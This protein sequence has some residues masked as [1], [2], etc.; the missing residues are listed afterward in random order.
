MLS[1]EGRRALATISIATALAAFGFAGC[2]DDETD[3]SG[4]GGAG[5]G[6]AGGGSGG[7]SG[8]AGSAG[9]AASDAPELPEVCVEAPS[10]AAW[11]GDASCPVAKPAASDALDEAFT[12]AGLDRCSYGFSAQTMSIWKT[13][14]A[15]DAYKLPIFV[16]LHEGLLRLPG[17]GRETE[18][19]LA[20]ALDGETPVADAI[21]AAAARK[22]P[23]IQGCADLTP[24]QAALSD[25]E[26]LARA[27]VALTEAHG[28]SADQAA[29]AAQTSG[30]PDELERALVPVLASL[31]F[32]VKEQQAAWGSSDPATLDWLAQI[33]GLLLASSSASFVFDQAHVAHLDAVDGA[34][35]AKAAAL[36]ARAVELADLGRF[37]GAALTNVSVDTPLGAIVIGAATGDTYSEGHA[38]ERS[39]LLIDVGGDDV[40]EVPVAAGRRDLPVSVAIDLGGADTYAYRE[41]RVGTDLPT[42]LVS[43]G[44]GRGSSFAGLG[45][46]RSRIGR[47]GSGV[48]GIGLL[49]DL[50]TENDEYRSLTLSQGAA[51]MGVG[52]LFDAGGDDKYSS[53]ALSQGAALFGVGLLLDSKGVDE[54]RTFHLAQ[55]FGYVQGVGVL[56]DGDGND[57][58]F[59]DPGDPAL[60]GDP[61]YPS[62]QLPGKG[63]SSM[64]QGTGFG[65]R[66]DAGGLYMAGGHGILFDR[67]GD[68][69]YTASV[70][71]QASGY[72]L[73][74]GMLI[75][76]AGADVYEGLWYVQ[77]S[78]AHF[79]LAL[80]LEHGGGDRYN[81]SFPVAATSIGVGHDFSGSLHLDE[82]G[83]DRYFA[84]GLSLGCGNE[85]GIG[86]VINIGGND[87]YASAGDRT[88]G[89]AALGT[90]PYNTTRHVRPTAGLFVDVEGTDT[91]TLAAG[92]P[93]AADGATWSKAINAGQPGAPASEMSG[94]VDRAQGQAQI[95]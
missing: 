82:G 22:H 2:G 32:A 77:G 52:V 40:Y 50:G 49:F 45:Q 9:D 23:S 42:R 56:A 27:I 44:S 30:L 86:G 17:Y 73:G 74:F 4:T 88:L 63:N 29:I 36:V 91:Y 75:D 15:D 95:P 83:D 18:S 7:T 94:G 1:L 68:D 55:G 60:G 57:V 28:G 21:L 89:C 84:P 14:F 43:D 47:Q 65:R 25:P 11:P 80:F 8:S 5:T 10:A 54:Y 93:A 72:W 34:R 62:P 12:Q 13:I 76:A 35:I 70:F 19:W 58:Y 79:A 51:A 39:A 81:E 90:A 41:Q 3:A 78:T 48:L 66:D 46:T 6:G 24:F 33:H 26:P 16:P 53:E 38:A 92:G 59:A 87:H 85:Q 20:A 71:A 31:S 69:H 37:A 64:V 67:A 61:L